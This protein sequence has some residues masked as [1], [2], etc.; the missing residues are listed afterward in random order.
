MSKPLLFVGSSS[1]QL[2]MVDQL[3]TVLRDR[4]IAVAEPWDGAFPPGMS[5]LE[6]LTAKANEVDFALFVFGPD[7][8]TRSRG[9]ESASARD[10]VIFEAGL[11]GGVLGMKRSIILHARGVKV[12][13][14]L[15]GLTTIPYDPD[16]RPE[17]EAR[18][19]CTKMREV[20]ERVGWR[21]SEGLAGQLHGCWW[22]WVLSDSERTERSV[23]SLMDIRR[24]GPR[25]ACLS[26]VSWTRDGEQIS[27]YES[28]ATSLDEDRRTLFYYWEGEW[29]GH[30]DTPQFFGKGEITV[31]APGRGYGYFTIRSD[32]DKDPRERKS[33]AYRRADPA[34]VLIVR[35]Q[36]DDKR[37]AVIRKQLASR[38][39]LVFVGQQ[40]K[41]AGRPGRRRAR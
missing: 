1:E 17:A 21:G 8:R 39:R 28:K 22:Q 33:T 7:D 15:L 6:A 18:A 29:P 3:L 41:G 9:K 19:V 36:D 12:P 38:A 13:S 37:K 20:I 26:G 16:A 25:V 27:R 34:D 4:S 23:L 24:T 11:F 14:D 32:G 10:N 5:A 2:D 35:G 31:E 40:S 30:P